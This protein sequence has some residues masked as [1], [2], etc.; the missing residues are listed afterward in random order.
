[1]L[2]AQVQLGMM[3]GVGQMV[4]WSPVLSQLRTWSAHQAVMETSLRKDV[5]S[6]L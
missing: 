6:S 1:M 4:I 5:F 2:G 3:D